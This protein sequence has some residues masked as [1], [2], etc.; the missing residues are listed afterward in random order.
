[1]TLQYSRLHKNTNLWSYCSGNNTNVVKLRLNSDPMIHKKMNDKGS[2]IIINNWTFTYHHSVPETTSLPVS[3][4]RERQNGKSSSYCF[5]LHIILIQ[6][7][8][9]LFLNH[10]KCFCEHPPGSLFGT[11]IWLF[12][13]AC[14]MSPVRLA[15]CCS[16]AF[17]LSL[18]NKGHVTHFNKEIIS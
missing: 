11:C 7:R 12:H 18:Q 15:I 9:M 6:F 14:W 10:I 2:I 17:I 3:H 13:K 16:I 5:H 1:M 4:Y 8:F